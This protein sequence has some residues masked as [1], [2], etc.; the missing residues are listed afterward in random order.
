MA[1][2]ALSP[3]AWRFDA[4]VFCRGR[5]GTFSILGWICEAGVAL[6]VPV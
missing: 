4:G 6:A 1:G 5:R 2:V 3:E